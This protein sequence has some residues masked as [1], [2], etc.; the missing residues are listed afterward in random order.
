MKNFLLFTFFI[1]FVNCIHLAQNKQS[2]PKNEKDSTTVLAP[3]PT[4]AT[5]DCVKLHVKVESE[6]GQ[7]PDDLTAEFYIDRIEL[8][9]KK[10]KNGECSFTL[11]QTINHSHLFI[12]SSKMMIST[13]HSFTNGFQN[14]HTFVLHIKKCNK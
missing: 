11:Y 6:D 8:Q 10:L 2:L 13:K 14:D 3:N 5:I 9:T 1:L 7:L 4:D 12:K